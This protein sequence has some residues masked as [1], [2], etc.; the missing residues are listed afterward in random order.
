MSRS[1]KIRPHFSNNTKI[2]SP[3]EVKSLFFDVFSAAHVFA[4]IGETFMNLKMLTIGRFDGSLEFLEREDLAN[5]QQLTELDI[6]NSLVKS[7]DED[8]FWDLPNLE[9]LR[10]FKSQLKKIPLNLFVNMRK[11]REVSF[12]GNQLTSLDRD[13]FKN[14]PQLE[15]VV[16]EDN[17]I[18]TIKVDFTKFARVNEINFLGNVC[19]NLVFLE[20]NSRLSSVLSVH[21]F[22]AAINRTC[23]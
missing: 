18:V 1:L 7:L 10:F 21:E 23:Y 9:T 20:A 12:H 4:G 13:L 2:Q 19:T 15:S 3:R 5:M 17:K 16:F 8:V 22:Q 11:L 6:F 14:N